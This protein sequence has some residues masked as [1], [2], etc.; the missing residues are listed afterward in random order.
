MVGPDIQRVN[1]SPLER[2][3]DGSGPVHHNSGMCPAP[4][5]DRERAL[6]KSSDSSSPRIRCPCAAG[7]VACEQMA[8]RYFRVLID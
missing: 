1:E 6:D 8:N 4:V 2:F 3:S 5:I 7:A